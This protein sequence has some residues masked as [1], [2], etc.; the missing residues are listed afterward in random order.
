MHCIAKFCYCYDTC[1]SVEVG[2]S[3]SVPK[4]VWE[5]GCDTS[6]AIIDEYV[7]TVMFI[8]LES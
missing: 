7:H 5:P 6:L 2:A 8:R 3:N 1:T 4:M